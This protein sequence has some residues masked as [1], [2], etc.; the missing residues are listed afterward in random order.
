MGKNWYHTDVERAQVDALQKNG[1]SQRQISRQI[2]VNRSSVQRAIK[3]FNSE[4]INGNRKKNG[5]PRKTIARDDNTIKRIVARSLTSSC[6]KLRAN[7]LRKSADV[8]ISTISRFL[9]KHRIWI[10]IL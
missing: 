8:S 10:K 5:R 4:G 7:L 9:S 6:K 3:K 2:V 1:L